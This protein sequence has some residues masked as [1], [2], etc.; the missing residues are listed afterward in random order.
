MM[1]DLKKVI[2]ETCAKHIIRL[3]DEDMDIIVRAITKAS[4]D[5]N[6]KLSRDMQRIDRL[7]K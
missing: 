7:S 3:A 5:A 2:S 4:M 1:V 6:E